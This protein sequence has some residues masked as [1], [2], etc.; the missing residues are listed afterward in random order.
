MCQNLLIGRVTPARQ[1]TAPAG[2]STMKSST[3]KSSR[4]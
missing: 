3:V 2:S 1:V 4:V